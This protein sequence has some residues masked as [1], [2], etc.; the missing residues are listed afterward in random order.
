VTALPHGFAVRLS[1]SV[2]IRDNGRTLIGG[3]PLRV[4]HLSARARQLLAGGILRAVDADST[5]LAERL[6]A[7]GMA[8]PVTAL[9]DEVPLDLVTCVV[10]VRDRAAGLDRLLAGL[11]RA[12][13]IIVVDDAS[14]DVPAIADVSTRHGAEL[15]PLDHHIGQAGA[16]NAG[17]RRVCTP[18]VLFID[19]DVVIDVESMRQLLRHFH[20]PRVAAVAPRIRGLEA[21]GSWISRYEAASSSLDLGPDSAPVR[22]ASPVGWVPTAVLAARV[23][24]VGDGFDASMRVGEDVDLVW[25]L[26][27]DGW[28]VRYDAE[29]IARH[30]HRTSLAAWLRRKAFYGSSADALASRHGSKVSPAVF[31]PSG[32]AI[33]VAVLAQR[34]WSVPTV[35]A[36]YAA[37]TARLSRKVRRSDHPSR[38]AAELA[39]QGGA[40]TLS[41]LGHLM[42]RHWWP[43]TAVGAVLSRRVRRAVV[44][45]AVADAVVEHRRASP[46]LD[47]AS[48]ALAR[49]ADDL[50]YGMGLWVGAIRGRS[51]RALLP[52]LRTR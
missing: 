19:S 6:L 27:A 35:C 52:R 8:E 25:R 2:R 14:G 47:L 23:E 1:S 16:R 26:V 21:G 29:I 7:S 10:P 40:S 39:A 36:L 20:D 50:A 22:P 31:T 13:R 33:S 48:Y 49:R 46:D 28:T 5:A 41:Q 34:S 15:L 38:L 17:L 12:M 44:V 37:S 24:A 45:A 3:A 32:A 30:D 18:Y 9:L 4:S 11:A 42:L 51:L 43:L